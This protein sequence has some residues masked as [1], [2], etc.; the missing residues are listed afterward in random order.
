[1]NSIVTYQDVIHDS[2]FFEKVCSKY[3]DEKDRVFIDVFFNTFTSDSKQSK[4]FIVPLSMYACH[5]V[6][7]DET[8]PVSLH[9]LIEEKLSMCFEEKTDYIKVNDSFYS[10]YPTFKMF[11][12]LSKNRGAEVYAMF[13]DIEQMFN[14]RFYELFNENMLNPERIK[15][16][17]MIEEF[18]DK[19]VLYFAKLRT[20]HDG[21]MF[22][23]VGHTNQLRDMLQNVKTTYKKIPTLLDVYANENNAELFES[24][25]TRFAI[26]KYVDFNEKVDTT[27]L[28]VVTPGVY[29][30]MKNAITPI[31]TPVTRQSVRQRRRQGID[32]FV[33]LMRLDTRE[34]VDFYT[35][36]IEAARKL[37]MKQSNFVKRMSTVSPNDRKG[38]RKHRGVDAFYWKELPEDV[39]ENY[40]RDHALPEPPRFVSK[41]PYRVNVVDKDNNIIEENVDKEEISRRYNLTINSIYAYIHKKTLHKSGFYFVPSRVGCENENDNNNGE[42]G[43]NGGNEEIPENEVNETQEDYLESEEDDNENE[44]ENEAST[45]ISA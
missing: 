20:T 38:F 16:S 25:N 35:T 11:C 43:E 26:Y 7:N 14:A 10:N 31:T 1:M 23:K 41:K 12:K 6:K 22:I 39:K 28:F 5:F 29:E 34:I 40:L 44:N 9:K 18:A 42:N 21:R 27:G 3:P 4:D 45:S 8:I 13:E 19:D 33:V 36:C 32:R 30:N 15:E 37:G 24:L 17:K 2:V